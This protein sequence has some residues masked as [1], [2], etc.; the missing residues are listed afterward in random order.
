MCS[1][2]SVHA[3]IYKARILTKVCLCSCTGGGQAGDSVDGPLLGGRRHRPHR[4]HQRSQ[5]PRAKENFEIPG[6]VVFLKWR[7]SKWK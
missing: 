5:R 6:T 3:T 2:L 7:I 4:H 1:C